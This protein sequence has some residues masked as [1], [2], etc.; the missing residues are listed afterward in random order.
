MN[1]AWIVL[2]WGPYLVPAPGFPARSSGLFN[3]MVDADACLSP[4]GE[5][6]DPGGYAPY[7]K[8]LREILLADSGLQTILQVVVQ[9]S[10]DLS[11]SLR[12]ERASPATPSAPASFQLRRVRAKK[13]VWSEMMEEMRRQQGS[14]MHLGDAE[15][16]RALVK[17][18]R[19]SDV[20]IVAVSDDLANRLVGAWSGVLARPRHVNEVLVAPDGCRLFQ[21]KEDGTTY[22]FWQDGRSGITHSPEPGSLLGELVAVTEALAR[23]VET[24]AKGQQ[25]ATRELDTLVDRL[26]RRI[27]A[28][29][30]CVRPRPHVHRSARK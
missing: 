29:E 18:S 7:T 27:Q 26:Q 16:Q 21:V 2:A 3:Y 19:A 30:P 5:L 17:V 8:V 23:Y 22:D 24:P 12:L 11:H 4:A 20:A 28:N 15:Q 1:V 6:S 9:P 10:F 14:V 13:H 25:T